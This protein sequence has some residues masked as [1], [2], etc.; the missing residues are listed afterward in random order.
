MSLL[1]LGDHEIPTSINMETSKNHK[2]SNEQF[3]TS[4]LF[5]ITNEIRFESKFESKFQGQPTKIYNC[6]G[7]T[8]ASKRTGVFLDS[9]INLILNDEYREIKDKKDV[10]IGD[11]VIYYQSGSILHSALVVNIEKEP[12]NI[13]V[14]S[15]T[16]VYKEI[17]HYLQYSPYGLEYKFY[18]INHEPATI[19]K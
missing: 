18:R 19:I 10:L 8:F 6:H 9:A 17:V 4:N 2:I 5:E 14:L 3:R 11:L 12:I 7:L 13:K 16:R 1:I 15:K